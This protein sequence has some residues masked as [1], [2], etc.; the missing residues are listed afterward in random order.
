MRGDP[1]FT[2]ARCRRS[3]TLCPRSSCRIRI[4]WCVR[5]L[6]SNLPRLAACCKV[7]RLYTQ[8]C[9]DFDSPPHTP[10]NISIGNAMHM[11]SAI[12]VKIFI[13]HIATFAPRA[14]SVWI[15][16]Y[17]VCGD[18]H[19]SRTCVKL[20]RPARKTLTLSPIL[21]WTLF[22]RFLYV[23]VCVWLAL[24]RRRR[25]HLVFCAISRAAPKRFGCARWIVF[26]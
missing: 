1:S 8:E 25:A 21:I 9:F 22:A 11:K 10:R 3:D 7:Y 13:R 18:D 16:S 23:S 17:G 14:A 2:G 5:N 6:L 12:R 15:Y 4:T 26:A 20:Q 24:L 19:L